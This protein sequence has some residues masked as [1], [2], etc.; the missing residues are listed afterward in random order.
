MDIQGL[1]YSPLSQRGR[2]GGWII[3]FQ[4]VLVGW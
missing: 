1:P 2:S 3:V 4:F